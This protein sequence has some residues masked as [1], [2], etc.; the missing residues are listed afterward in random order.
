[1]V[2]AGSGGVSVEGE[3]WEV[4]AAGIGRLD[5]LE[6]TDAGLYARVPV[7]LLPPHAGRAVETYL[8][9]QSVEGR[10]DLGTAYG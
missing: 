1:M 3:L 7:R 8:Y 6:G 4:D 5:A 10:R 9:R 2:A